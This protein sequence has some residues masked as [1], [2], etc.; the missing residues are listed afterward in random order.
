MN[1]STSS[2]VDVACCQMCR[3]SSD[4]EVRDLV[5]SILKHIMT[6]NV[7]KLDNGKLT[8]ADKSALVSVYDI[9]KLRQRVGEHASCLGKIVI[10]FD[11]DN[12]MLVGRE[13]GGLSVGINVALASRK[14]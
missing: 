7:V 3:H 10:K 12:I 11:D 2:K 5:T 9:I 6:Y 1:E 4:I 14:T 8:D 13:N